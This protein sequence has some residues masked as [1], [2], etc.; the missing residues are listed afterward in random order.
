VQ[1]KKAMNVFREHGESPIGIDTSKH[2]TYDTIAGLALCALVS[3]F[4][5]PAVAAGDAIAGK[6][7][8][9]NQCASCHTVEVGKNGFGPSLAGVYE[10]K[11]GSLAGYTYSPAMV[12]LLVSAYS[13]PAPTVQPTREELGLPLKAS[14][15]VA[16]KTLKFALPP[17][18]ATPPVP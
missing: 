16:S 17:P 8:F 10:R 13:T 12:Q 2:M 5:C 18:Y 15:C 14:P 3:S 1:Y 9:A 11:A 6:T 4:S 7:V